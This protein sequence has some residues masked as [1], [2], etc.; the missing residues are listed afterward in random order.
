MAELFYK[1]GNTARAVGIYRK[2]VRER[3]HDYAVARRLRELEHLTRR[4]GETMT[5]REHM[6]RIV[7]AVP[8]ATAC[9]LMGFDGI[10][11]DSYEVGG[12]GLDIPTLLAEYSGAAQL[13]RHNSG[14]PAAGGLTE[15]TITTPHLTAVLRP[16]NEDYF[17]AVVL[18]TGG[19]SGKARYLMRQAAPD[20]L[21]E[22]S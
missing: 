19:L 1:Q 22:L 7:E 3:P 10:A 20:L 14:Q 4:P 2:V 9:A 6:Q 5:F 21:R 16:L 18:G 11:I 17:L 12:G 8:G 15:L 13:L